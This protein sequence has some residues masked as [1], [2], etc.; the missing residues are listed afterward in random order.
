MELYLVDEAVLIEFVD[1]LLREKYSDSPIDNYDSVERKA[2]RTLD[3]QISEAIL[4]SLNAEQ[5]VE[6]ERLLDDSS[7][8]PSMFQDFFNNNGIDLQKIIEDTMANFRSEFLREGN[9]E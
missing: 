1:A 9:N 5:V 3:Q 6:L 4:G 2:V 7:A 8:K